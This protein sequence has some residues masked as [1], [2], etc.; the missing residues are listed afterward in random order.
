MNSEVQ[1]RKAT[2]EDAFAIADILREAFAEFASDYTP[3]AFTVVTPPANEIAGRFDEGPIWVALKDDEIVGTVSAVPEPEWLY[4]RS[5]AVLPKA[6]GLGIG[7][8]LLDAIEEYGIENGFDRL[9]LYTTHFSTDAIRLYEKLG[10]RRGPDTSSE[11]W[12]G[13]PGLSM[14]K[15]LGKVFGQDF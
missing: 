13:T 15:R 9:F 3:E 1:I 8:G 6:Q 11:E 12:Y 2:V 5:M 4:I 7:G 14:D 10:F